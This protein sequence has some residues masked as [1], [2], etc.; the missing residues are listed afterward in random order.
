MWTVMRSTL[1]I[2]VSTSSVS[3]SL[4]EISSCAAANVTFLIQSYNCLDL[5]P[6][7]CSPLHREDTL[8]CLG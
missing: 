8:N 2:F 7:N 1:K 5:K 6:V 3:L 4:T